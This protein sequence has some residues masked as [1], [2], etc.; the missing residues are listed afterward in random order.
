[1]TAKSQL[2][3]SLAQMNWSMV[4][5][6]FALGLIGCAMMISAS[7]GHFDPWGTRQI[8]RFFVGFAL[9]LLVAC[10][11]QEKLL[12][13]AYTIYTLCLLMLI[14]VL[15]VGYMGKGAQRWVSLGVVN[16]QPSELMKIAAILA[17]A[18]YF[19]TLPPG[20]VRKLPFLIPP[21]ILLLLPAALILKQPNLGTATILCIVGAVMF[22]FAGV[23]LRIFIT[24]GLLGLAALPVA[25]HFMH[26]YQKQRVLT[27]LNPEADPL[28]AGYNIMQSMIAIGSGGLFGKGYLQG[29]QGQLDFLPEKQTDFIFTMYAEEFGFFGAML[30][31]ALYALLLFYGLMI[32]ARAR[33]KFG[34][35]LAAGITMML[36]AHV[37]INMAMVMG[38]IPVVGVPLPMLSYGG[39]FLIAMLIGFGLLLNAFI[40]RHQ[41]LGRNMGGR[42]I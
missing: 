35:L 26:D 15:A 7:G 1:M 32:A 17:L 34:S 27:F 13:H 2:Q 16:L 37:F 39:S 28:G 11:P 5:L 30:L 18:R 42:L 10:I 22:F 38:I 41:Q 19:H 29:S 3:R 24:L 8:P 40:H 6:I 33:S 14:V 20:A 4:W 23:R 36:F 9:M 31:L 12:R 25:W 21:A